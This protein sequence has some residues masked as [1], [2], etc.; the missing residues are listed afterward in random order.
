[1]PVCHVTIEVKQFNSF[2]A[3][4]RRFRKRVER[5]GLIQ[6]I[7]ACQHFEKPSD[8]RRRKSK[9]RRR[10]QQLQELKVTGGVRAY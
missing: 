3:A 1:M 10:Q 5:T 6:E 9:E 4:V 7:L 2:E 8:R